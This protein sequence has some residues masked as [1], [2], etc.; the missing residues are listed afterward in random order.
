MNQ[1][2]L[3]AKVLY[4]FFRAGDEEVLALKGISLRVDP[5]EFV[6]VVGPSGAGKSTLLACLSG[7]EEPSG[8]Q[9]TIAGKRISHRPE[10]ERSRIRARLIGLLHQQGNLFA[11]LTVED[12]IAAAQRLAGS[13]AR[14]SPRTLLASV[15]LS[16][17]GNA[18]PGQLSGG[19]LARAGLAVALANDPAVLLADEPTGELDTIAEAMILELMADAA[20]RGTAILV[21]SHSPQVAAAADR[22]VRL[23]DGKVIA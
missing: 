14:S 8:G 19:E 10:A 18:L 11:H 3:E 4:R 16:E 15:G 23:I 21:A 6:A 1:G 9:V 12:N 5:G 22:V 13:G 20:A 2:G 7:S 17:H